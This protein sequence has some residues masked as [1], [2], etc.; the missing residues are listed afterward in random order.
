[1]GIKSDLVAKRN[2]LDAVNAKVKKAREESLVSGGDFDLMKST[3][4]TGATL[5][6]RVNEMR[7]LKTKT[8]ELGKEVDSLV[9]AVKSLEVT[10]DVP[11]TKGM[12]HPEAKG[13]NRKSLG[14]QFTDS[15]EFKAMAD[16]GGA[17]EAKLYF[18]NI[19]I[20]T[21]MTTAAGYAGQ[22]IRT[23]ETE[24]YPTESLGIWNSF[25][26][27][28]TSQMSY[29]Y[30]EETTRTQAAAEKAETGAYA[31]SAFAF[32]ER[33]VPVEDIGHFIPVTRKQ[34]MDVPQVQGIIDGE[35]RLGLEELLEY[36][37]INGTGSTP[38]LQGMLNKTGINSLLAG[39]IAPLDAIYQAITLVQK[40][41]FA[42]P[43]L[44]FVNGED[45]QPIQLMKT[46]GG[47]YIWGHPADIGP[48]RVWGRKLVSTFRVAQGTAGVG[49][50]NRMLYAERM[51]ITVEI[52][53]SHDTYFIYNKLAIKCWTMGCY[54]WKRPLAFC[55]ITGLN[56]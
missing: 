56:S 15:K 21:L 9:E 55:K 54:V 37:G 41:G 23:G 34:L 30:M 11:E 32:T 39:G 44:V 18:P 51:G 27:R 12:Q 6:D 16:G 19:G 25:P 26:K 4:L 10:D 36:E 45:W 40:N 3:V 8:D 28:Q 43:N 52:S 20:K 42:E 46:L 47:Q 50:F 24:M 49:D 5:Q 13:V 2:E 53:D 35:L 38:A 7:T 48:M 14:E 29:V 17:S 22:A 33:S 1:M 31:E